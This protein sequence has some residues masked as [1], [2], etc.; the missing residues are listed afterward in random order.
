MSGI[1]TGRVE[2]RS[3]HFMFIDYWTSMGLSMNHDHHYDDLFI[4]LFIFVSMMSLP[5]NF[6][7]HSRQSLRKMH[8]FVEPKLIPMTE[9]L[10]WSRQSLQLFL[11]CKICQWRG[12]QINLQAANSTTTHYGESGLL[13]FLQH[14]AQRRGIV[15]KRQNWCDAAI[16]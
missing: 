15:V 3:L 10:A 8:S 7:Q 13:A 1:W 2:K 12:K 9:D 4:Y 5:R 14:C 16:I 6:W 11:N